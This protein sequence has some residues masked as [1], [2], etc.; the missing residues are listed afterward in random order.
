MTTR[1]PAAGPPAA[2][3]P[4]GEP[5]VGEPAV[6]DPPADGSGPVPVPPGSTSPALPAVVATTGRSLAEQVMVAVRRAAR[7]GE[8]EPGRLYSVQQLASVLQVSRSPV[9]EGLLRLGEAG[10]VRFHRNRGFEIVRP[11][12]CE[13]AEILVVRT[14]LEVPAARR[15]A[16]LAGAH[17]LEGL[18]RQG[19]A[20]ACAVRAGDA[21]AAVEADQRLHRLLM[22]AAGNQQA[23]R[24]VE[25]LWTATSILGAVAGPAA[26]P[27]AAPTAEPDAAAA[28]RDGLA[29]EHDALVAALV[30]RDEEAAALAVRAHLA[31]TACRL[32]ARALRGEGLV[33]TRAEQRAEELWNTAVRG[34]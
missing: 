13:V 26:P 7:A 10:L 29:A 4:A 17:D 24:L 20:V 8:M 18:R 21:D 30:A 25:Q 14:A 32:V 16:R 5:A 33:G 15:V 22:R 23:A 34:W 31:A 19:H 9:R 12:P 6:D 3:P 27:A 1:P 28:E 11:G 2:G